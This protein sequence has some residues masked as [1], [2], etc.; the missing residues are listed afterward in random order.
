MTLTDLILRY[1]YAA[2]SDMDILAARAHAEG[3]VLVAALV[4]GGFVAANDLAKL[5][6]DV[7]G[8][9][10]VDLA[11]GALEADVLRLVPEAVAFAK[12]A[13]PLDIDATTGALRVAFAD[14]TDADAIEAVCAAAGCAVIPVVATVPAIRSA[15][16]W[17]YGER[18][19]VSKKGK[20][21]IAPE[22]TRRV[23]LGESRDLGDLT[24]GRTSPAHRIDLEATLEQRVEALVLSLIEAGVITHAEYIAALKRLIDKGR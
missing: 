1:R 18:S 14:P 16:E 17:E 9:P 10:L 13:V 22:D 24:S 19:R 11:I 23:G 6:S 15:L 2:K 20:A 7:S 21:E 12:L 8:A 3:G 5:V 4:D